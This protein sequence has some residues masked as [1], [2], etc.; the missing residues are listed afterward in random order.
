MFVL[1]PFYFQIYRYSKLQRASILYGLPP[2]LP[3]LK[4]RA[5]KRANHSFTSI[6]LHH[7]FVKMISFWAIARKPLMSKVTRWVKIMPIGIFAV[8]YF[9]TSSRFSTYSASHFQ[10]VPIETGSGCTSWRCL[11]WLPVPI[12]Q[13]SVSS[14]Y[15]VKVKNSLKTLHI[16]HVTSL[17]LFPNS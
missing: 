8:D 6:F 2:L 12:T 9:V 5:V 7:F 4:N 1:G 15:Q 14:F 10:M 11:I 17:W 13:H 3:K 16:R